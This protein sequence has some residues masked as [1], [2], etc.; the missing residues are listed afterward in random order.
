VYV[1]DAGNRRVQVFDSRGNARDVFEPPPDSGVGWTRPF[2]I[3]VIGEEWVFV[4]DPPA[5]RIW[6]FHF[7]G[8]LVRK[9]G[10]TGIGRNE[11]RLPHG[12]AV[13]GAQRLFVVDFGNH[14]G[15]VFNRRGEFENAFG[16]RIFV[17]PA[18]RGSP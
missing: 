8:R 12:L 18:L 7:D 6:Q 9:W 16:S 14:R 15:Q 5:D 13:D 17:A 4:S 11:F 3:A 2:S 1:V 10:R